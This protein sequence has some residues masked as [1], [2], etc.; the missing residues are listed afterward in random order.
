MAKTQSSVSQADE[1]VTVEL[2]KDNGKYK[3]PLLV[4]VNGESC[5]IQRG[6]PVQVKRKFI[7]AIEQSQF[8]DK[9]TAQMIE[10]ETSAFADKDMRYARM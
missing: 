10:R 7:W 9:Q 1:L 3:D 8:Q 2:F 5:I 4:C 6:V